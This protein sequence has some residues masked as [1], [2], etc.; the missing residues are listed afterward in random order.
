LLGTLEEQATRTA[1]ATFS[2]L[3]DPTACGCLRALN[4]NHRLGGSEAWL[5]SMEEADEVFPVVDESDVAVGT[6]RRKVVH[7]RGLRHRS[8]H[9]LVFNTAGE[10]LVQLRAASKDTYPLHWDV[11]VG[12]HVCPGETYEQ[13]ARR[14]LQEEL[15]LAGEIRFLRKIPASQRTGWEFVAVYV[16]TTN[17]TPRPNA[18]EIVEC[19]FMALSGLL[20]EIRCSRLPATPALENALSLYLDAKESGHGQGSGQ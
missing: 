16:M 13:A 11:S 1:R 3:T 15:G 17:Q 4:S 20:A 2:I 8:A 10:L 18:H 19:R 7:E 9:V 12:G 6:E 14:E 5:L